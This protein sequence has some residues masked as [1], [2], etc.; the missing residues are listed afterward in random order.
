MHFYFRFGIVLNCLFQTFLCFSQNLET[1]SNIKIYDL[2][3]MSNFRWAVSARELPILSSLNDTIELCILD[4]TGLIKKKI[5]INPKVHSEGIKGGPLYVLPNGEILAWYG[6]GQ[7]DIGIELPVVE[8]YD[9][10]G[11]AVW[12]IFLSD[13]EYPGEVWVAPDSNIILHYVNRISKIS[14]TTGETIWQYEAN[15]LQEHNTSLIVVPGSEDLLLG[16][17][18][19]IKYF[20][21]N[22]TGDTISYELVRYYNMEQG[23]KSFKILGSDGNGLFY[24]EKLDSLQLY[25][26]R[27]DL[28]PIFILHSTMNIMESSFA[29]GFFALGLGYQDL[30]VRLY[31][32]TGQLLNKWQPSTDGLSITNFIIDSNRFA[33][34]GDYLSGQTADNF[35]YEPNSLVGREQGWFRYYPNLD[36]S[37]AKQHYSLSINNIIELENIEIDS[38]YVLWPEFEGYIYHLS[39]GKFN[40]E[41]QNT[42]S[43]PVHSFTINSGLNWMPQ[44]D[45]CSIDVP[46]YRNYKGYSILPGETKWVEFSELEGNWTIFPPPHFCFWTSAPNE[47]PDDFPSDDMFCMEN[48]VATSEAEFSHISLSPNP[49]NSRILIS[50]LTGISTSI[51]YRLIDIFGR[52]YRIDHLH[53]ISGQTSINIS[54]IPSGVYYFNADHFSRML[55]IQH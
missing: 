22:N 50:G 29:K 13:Y 17:K 27:L 38:T 45:I 31:D 5:K 9:T 34:A 10:A 33:V 20:V 3:P 32:T 37:D 11:Q 48:V 46:S 18:Q 30:D 36:L 19:G 42:G 12:H 14:I 39:H 54:D 15:F 41:L 28:Q 24:G 55:I 53:I 51:E 6:A 1:V 43:E 49:A 8:K 35:P 4:S 23:N 47:R 7:C 16:D 2:K 26:F 25:R 40:I 21:Q 44:N 52:I